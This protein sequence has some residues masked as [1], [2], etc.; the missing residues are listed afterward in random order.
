MPL[1]L[2]HLTSLEMLT[3]FVVKKGGFKA[4]SY[5]WCKKK[6]ARCERQTGEDWS[7]IAHVPRV[8]LDY[9]NQQ[10]ETIFSELNPNSFVPLHSAF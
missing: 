8:I 2:G 10:E 5:S 7:I 3:R 6:Q 9:E 4:S 1:G